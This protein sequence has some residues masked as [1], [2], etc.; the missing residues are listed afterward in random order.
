M[1]NALLAASRSNGMR[2][3]IETI[4]VTRRVAGRFVA[5]AS[6]DQAIQ[7]CTGLRDR[8]HAVT[9]DYLGEDIT[10]LQQAH[11]TVQAYHDLIDGLRSANLAAGNEVSVKLSALGQSLPAAGERF[12]L[13]RA[14][15]IVTYAESA[16]VLVTFDMED[17]TTTD[18]T[19]RIVEELRSVTP[20]VGCV[21]QA[22][23][24]RTPSDA[25]RLAYPGSRVRVTKGAYREPATVAHQEP[26]AINTGYLD[27][28][29]VLLLGQA[30]VMV[31]SHD[32]LIISSALKMAD[33]MERTADTYEFQM[34]Y[35]IRPDEQDRLRDL[36]LAT[37]VYVPYGD[38]WYGYFMRRLAERPANL[39]LFLK[40]LTS[41][42]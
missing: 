40:A 33:A 21:L 13:E 32:P 1:R 24:L 25:A 27:A 28:L 17:H 11:A 16:G 35:G 19:L 20:T 34:L 2:K 7:A 6:T 18:S 36:G 15:E 4:P 39:Q 30:Y 37:R 3:A 12:A 8:G 22:A 38:E 23:L 14:R 26:T 10:G 29:R 42:S 41:K 31:A 5:G 9:V